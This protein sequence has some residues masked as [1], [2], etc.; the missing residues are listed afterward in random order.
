[1]FDDL[2]DEPSPPAKK[3]F[4][5]A[6]DE[7]LHKALDAENGDDSPD[8]AI[9]SDIFRPY[10]HTYKLKSSPARMLKSRAILVWFRLRC[11]G[12]AVET[13]V[14]SITSV[15][16]TSGKAPK[17]WREAVS[18]SVTKD[19]EGRIRSIGWKK[20]DTDKNAGEFF[21]ECACTGAE[22]RAILSLGFSALNASTDF[23]PDGWD[24]TRSPFD[25]G[26]S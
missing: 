1:M 25:W 17:T 4:S 24:E 2:E 13:D 20:W 26:S 19:K 18:K 12:W 3:S 23:H 21:I 6:S 10:D 7:M 14:V 5:G 15:E 22:N 8:T 16:P 11:P 9:S